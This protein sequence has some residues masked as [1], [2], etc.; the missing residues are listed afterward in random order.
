MESAQR[1]GLYMANRVAALPANSWK[2]MNLLHSLAL[3]ISNE[4]PALHH[5]HAYPQLPAFL[6]ISAVHCVLVFRAS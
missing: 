4:W 5:I 3:T 6:A 2:S 1:H